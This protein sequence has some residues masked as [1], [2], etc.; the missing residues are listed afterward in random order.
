MSDRITN[1]EALMFGS[2]K[3]VLNILRGIAECCSEGACFDCPAAYADERDYPYCSLRNNEPG[4]C[5]L[6]M[7]AHCDY[8]E[9]SEGK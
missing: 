4:A 3:T 8:L 1:R 5:F 6:D 2:E 9:R 7:P